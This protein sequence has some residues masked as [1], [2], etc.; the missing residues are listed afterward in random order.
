MS[1]KKFT[2]EQ[3]MNELK[4]WWDLP[5]NYLSFLQEHAKSEYYEM[6]DEDQETLEIYL[7]GAEDLIESQ[8]GYAFHPETR[9]VFED[10][11]PKLV[12]IAD[13]DADPFCIDITREDS[14]VY[15][16]SH[17]MGEWDF[18]EFCDSL[19]EFLKKLGVE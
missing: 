9:E 18:Y 3:I 15:S 5:E 11:D 10:W 14:P 12:V 2:S 4:A 16:A 8:A 7:Y 13:L 17:G 1:E 6:E 19:E